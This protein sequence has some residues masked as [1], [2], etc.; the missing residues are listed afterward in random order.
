M[1]DLVDP[2][3]SHRK[4][5]DEQLIVEAVQC[6]E[7]ICVPTPSLGVALE[8]DPKHLQLLFVASF[9]SNVQFRRK[10]YL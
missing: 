1:A 7:E 4:M 10:R 3:S 2:L 8:T 5:S 6:L 9:N